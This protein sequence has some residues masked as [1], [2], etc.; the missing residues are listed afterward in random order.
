MSDG[1]HSANPIPGT[2]V[3]ASTLASA[4][5]FSILTPSRIS[6][7][8]VQR[9]NVCLAQIFLNG[10][11]PDW[12][13]KILTPGAAS[14]LIESFSNANRLERVAHPFN[15]CFDGFRIFRMAQQDAVDAGGEYLF[16]HPGVGTL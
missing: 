12:R 6:P 10:H 3:L 1:P 8:G 9:P 5:L 13:G 4:R 16:D 2:F 14:P 7:S 11:T 15:E